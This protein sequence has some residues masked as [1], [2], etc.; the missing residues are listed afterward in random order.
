MLLAKML[1][2]P[3]PGRNSEAGGEKE[4]FIKIKDKISRER[5]LFHS[6]CLFFPWGLASTSSL[7]T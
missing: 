5:G 7:T 1:G 3:V 4:L 2:N 6:C